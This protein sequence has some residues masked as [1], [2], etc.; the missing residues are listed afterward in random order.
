M[1]TRRALLRLSGAAALAGCATTGAP[2]RRRPGLQLA[3]VIV[4]PDR[5]I[6]TVVGLRPFRPSGFRVEAERLGDKLVVHNYGHG[7]GGVTL[8]W[9]TAEL[10]ARLVP[11][12]T[13]VAVLG[14]G[15]VGLATAHVLL[16]RGLQVTIYA[17]SL[18][19]DTTSDVAGAQIFPF[20]VFEQD[21]L[22]PPFRE[23]FLEAARLSFRAFQLLVGGAYGVRWMTNYAA[24]G[25]A[26]NEGGL[27]GR[28]SPIRE[29]LV[30][31][32]DLPPGT[33]TLP[34]AF[35]RRFQTMMVEPAVYL[36]A[37]LRDVRQA[38]GTVIVR[39]FTT[40]DEL[41]GLPEAVIVNCT[42]L[43]AGALFGDPSLIPVKGQLH[44]LLP[45]PEVEYAILCEG[46][47]MFARRDGILLG[48]TFQ[49]GVS[50]LEPDLEAR[51]AIYERHAAFFAEVGAARRSR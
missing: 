50:S 2:V 15:A 38:G 32:A 18:P 22:V 44:V 14:S 4:S 34:R 17:A 16:R 21:A 46:A 40:V 7:G 30:D 47:H 37:L 1:I 12:S 13:R 42:G 31:L 41:L 24:S 43:G 25:H 9:G 27:Q 11:A 10:A 35:V 3:P 51:A 23:Q 29:L 20:S 48:G 45:Q 28:Q 36:P 5:E 26:W 33:H 8:S 49:K 6:R 19:P 39:R